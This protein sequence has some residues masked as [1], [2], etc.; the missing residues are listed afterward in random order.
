MGCC[1]KVSDDGRSNNVEMTDGKRGKTGGGKWGNPKPFDPTFNGPIKNR[2]CTDI[3]CCIIFVVYI[4]GMIVLGG[5]A[6]NRG[7]PYRLLNSVDS[8][9]NICG[10]DKIVKD[11]P[12]LVFFDLRECVSA[13]T[14]VSTSLF[15][16]SCPT[17][18]RCVKECPDQN[19]LGYTVNVSDLVCDYDLN[20][21]NFD[22]T[23][24]DLM[25]FISKKRCAPYYLR[26]T[27]V[28]N[29]CIPTIVDSSVTSGLQSA[30][31]TNITADE[32]KEGAL[33]VQALLNLQNLG[34]RILSD[35]QQS[36]YW[37]LAA[38]GIAMVASL[39]YIILMRWLAG[40]IV[41]VTI[42]AILTALG[43]A[44]Y[45]C[46]TRYKQDPSNTDNSSSNF[47]LTF[48]TGLDSFI[49]SQE[50]WK[51][52][53]IIFAVILGILLLILLAVHK[54]ISIA[55]QI[56]KEGS[57]AVSAVPFTLFFPVIPW[58]LQLILFAWFLGVLAYIVTSG[59]PRFQ[60]VSNDTDNGQLCSDAVKAQIES[61]SSGLGNKTCNFVD[62]SD[63]N[64][65]LGMTVYHL[66]GWL[67]VMNFII[68]LGLA[69]LAGS[70]ASYYWAW[71]KKTDIPKFAVT[72]S[73]FRTLRYHT[74]SLAFGS[75][76]IAI[77]Q[78][79][80]IVLEYLDHKLRGNGEP[81]QILK[82]LLKCLKCCFWCLEK[83]LK[84]LNKNAYIMM[85]VHG[86]NFCTSAKDAFFLLMRNVVRVVVLDKVTDFLL[87]LGKLTI[88]AGLG[89]GSFYWFERQQDQNF[90]FY[91]API[92]V[93]V[94]GAYVVA[95]AFFGVYNM[96]IDTIFLSFLEDS[97]RNDGSPEKPY[98]M[99]K[100]LK[101]IVG[102]KNK[103]ESES[104]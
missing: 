77:V 72:A 43:F 84:F 75:L 101:K 102:K 1:G 50:T 59:S 9:G 46:W 53:A 74:G 85:A 38:L 10:H 42:Y 71:D 49:T 87:F 15:G 35:L 79:I 29:R 48:S 21:D 33:A 36:W 6:F 54:R 22:P 67:W 66:L 41:W 68:A 69:V 26:S 51:W 14:V 78:L 4:L 98:Y 23:P 17:K 25:D 91:L 32:V 100:S 92:I 47:A 8:D 19:A 82:Y 39:L 88:T 89:V 97:E 55:I 63:E 3:I 20:F 103:V 104:E 83:F 99:S 37:I 12:K 90:N 7:N 28:I 2:S 16:A 76:I 62:F 18:Q 5:I 93:I 58:L 60:V 11:R 95:H 24:Q 86:K 57:R 44:V 73:F 30:S 94:V 40:L 61:V 27:D 52:L 65:L 13:S 56:I 96:A 64:V 80:R 31:R 34:Q 81:N 45:Y 70:F